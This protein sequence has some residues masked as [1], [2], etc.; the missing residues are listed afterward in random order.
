M[1]KFLVVATILLLGSLVFGY[2]PTPAS[3]LD[4]NDVPFIYDINQCSSEPIVALIIP[5]GLVSTG[6]IEIIEPDGDSVY[7]SLGYG[8]GITIASEP[9]YNEK[10]PNDPLGMARIYRYEWNWTPTSENIGLHYINIHVSDQYEAFDERTMIILVK[11]NK[12]PVI[13]GCMD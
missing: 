12:A 3:V 11:E 13:T 7:I 9:Y 1:K 10:D 8:T 5:V 6:N 2:Q 4:P